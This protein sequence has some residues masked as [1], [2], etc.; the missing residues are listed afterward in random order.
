MDYAL[1]NRSKYSKQVNKLNN[2]ITVRRSVIE[3]S[4]QDSN[5]RKIDFYIKEKTRN[6]SDYETKVDNLKNECRSKIEQLQQT[7]ENNLQK[8]EQHYQKYDTYCNDGMKLD[9][10]A[11]E[12][13][14][15]V[16]NK[17]KEELKIAEENYAAADKRFKEEEEKQRRQTEWDRRMML[18]QI[19]AEE[20]EEKERIVQ[21]AKEVKAQQ[22]AD[23]EKRRLDS[24]R[25]EELE[26]KA[27]EYN[28]QVAE[29]TS[30]KADSFRDTFSPW[31]YKEKKRVCK[32]E[33][34]KLTELEWHYY[35]K[36]TKDQRK[37]ILE[38][39]NLEDIK[40]F[41]NDAKQYI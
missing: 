1:E 17:Y 16:I 34:G 11:E 13:K 35:T 27:K 22:E 41:L 19:E 29:I 37:N 32:E 7:L 23:R 24:M 8:L 10:S 26:E 2:Q 3:K 30:Y 6:R 15:K 31:S 21:K 12:A 33:E 14:D 4:A 5:S 39:S 40:K 28:K 18:Q 20:Q 36:L 9:I 25:K 38:L